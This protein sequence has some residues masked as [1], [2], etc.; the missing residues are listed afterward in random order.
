M[1][2]HHPQT[3]SDISASEEYTSPEAQLLSYAHLNR[4]DQITCFLQQNPEME[5][6]TIKDA[7]RYS[8]LHIACLNN[9]MTTC[10]YFLEYVTKKNASERTLLLWVNS[11]TDEGFTPLHFASFKGNIQLIKLLENYGADI[12]SKN[13]QGLSV[14]H[15]AAQGDQPVS[16]AY[17]HFRG[18]SIEDIDVKGSTPLHWASFL[19]MENSVTYLTSWGSPL[20]IQDKESG[21]T[22]LHLAVI[23][24]NPRVVRRLLVKGAKK[25]I[26][27]KEGKLPLDLAVDNEYDNIVLLLQERNS[28]L[29]RL[30]I[31][32]GL[33]RKRSRISLL[34]FIFLF[35]ILVGTNLCF[36]FPYVENI[37]WVLLFSFFASITLILFLISWLK[38][39]GIMKNRNKTDIMNLLLNN[40]PY[41][42]CPEC[43]IVRPPRSKHCEVCNACISV[44]DHHCPW[45]DNCVG[46]KNHGYFLAFT[47][48]VLLTVVYLAIFAGTIFLTTNKEFKPNY[49]Y[50][51]KLIP[52]E[53]ILL[54][55]KDITCWLNILIT[56]LFLAPLIGLNYV[57]I[58]NVVTGKTTSERYGY[59][60][61]LNQTMNQSQMSDADNNYKR[62]QESAKNKNASCFR[63]C[64]L[65]CCLNKK[66]KKYNYQSIVSPPSNSR[67]FGSDLSP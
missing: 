37:T 5:I 12:H 9:Q 35:L 54:I 52:D 15:I 3:L 56:I 43:V 19:G 11:R 38:D 50:F 22:P 63:N 60:A 10:R 66:D 28:C 42:V 29:Q 21:L 18:L 36:I 41:F 32:P 13:N 45:I 14:I 27:N 49:K 4:L 46:S 55:L 33:D 51:P 64:L 17:F 62:L 20:N 8:L 26:K 2:N 65:M 6:T 25:N 53:K 1:N 58:G 31:R 16:M 47:F 61:S 67:N 44:Y 48:W 34:F 40:D 59:N 39:P 24:G 57:Q 30:N 7:R 23:S